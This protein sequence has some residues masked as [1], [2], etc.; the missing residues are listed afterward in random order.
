MQSDCALHQVVQLSH[1]STNMGNTDVDQQR[2]DNQSDASTSERIEDLK[3]K[4]K[5]NTRYFKGEI[6]KLQNLLQASPAPNRLI[7]E[8]RVEALNELHKKYTGFV[9]ALAD[10][11]ELLDD[12]ELEINFDNA[13]V[14]ATEYISVSSAPQPT[15]SYQN[16]QLD[17]IK[18]P[19]I[20]LPSFS[21]KYSEWT[22]FYDTFTSLI[23]D[24]LQIS[25]I[26]K[27]HYLKSALKGDAAQHIKS[28]EISSAN[29]ETA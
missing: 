1:T 7:L 19:P 11:G 16:S 13:L 29:Y 27:F 20:Q 15:S 10:E 24:N 6:T 8:R 2:Q 17:Q 26:Q 14:K 12:P 5:G 18:L 25:S 22:S 28:I 3:K 21:G 23:H 9:Q 4:L